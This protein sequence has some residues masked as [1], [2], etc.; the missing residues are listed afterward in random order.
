MDS[1]YS[2][3]FSKAALTG[4]FAGFAATLLCIAYNTFFRA[5]TAFSPS[6]FINVSSLI[7][8]TNLL[9]FLIGIVYYAFLQIRK[10]EFLY[11]VFFALLTVVFA[12][13]A[14]HIHRS[15][16]PMLNTEFH[17]LLVPMVIIMGVI[18]TFGI[19]F[20]FHS[21]KFDEHVV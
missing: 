19:P 7:F 14:N 6:Y 20:L 10:G 8:V 3:P 17:H 11:V 4:V 13:M 21:K 18:A 12:F 15:D 16:V 2:T 5:S 1:I 9:F